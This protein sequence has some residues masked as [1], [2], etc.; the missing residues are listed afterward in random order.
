MLLTLN[1]DPPHVTDLKS[2]AR[3]RDVSASRLVTGIIDDL[4]SESRP[5]SLG[6]S[7]RRLRQHRAALVLRCLLLL[8]VKV[9]HFIASRS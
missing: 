5:P 8:N 3:Q 4:S 1:V 7:I 9:F 2:H 6:Q